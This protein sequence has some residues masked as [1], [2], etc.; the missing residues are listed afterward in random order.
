MLHQKMIFEFFYAN[1]LF[2]VTVFT[3]FASSKT[4]IPEQILLKKT[5]EKHLLK[6]M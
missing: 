4:N 5:P 2:L 6:Y 3:D 1:I